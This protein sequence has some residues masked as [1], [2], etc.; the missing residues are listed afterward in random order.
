MVRTASL[1]NL[2][3]YGY[4]H[5]LSVYEDEIAAPDV[6]AHFE[7]RHHWIKVIDTPDQHLWYHPDSPQIGAGYPHFT[8]DHARAAVDWLRGVLRGPDPYVKLLI[9]C[10]MGVSRSP[11]LFL[12]AMYLLRENRAS[13]LD[14]AGCLFELL[15]F[16][17]AT[18]PNVF[19][20]SAFDTVL[21]TDFAALVGAWKRVTLNFPREHNARFT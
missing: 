2:R 5:L 10:H 9:H 14:E 16:R 8:V 15:D 12:I 17:P 21:G 11:A 20:L 6:L 4:T 7:D 19:I 13:R 18:H 1:P 3:N